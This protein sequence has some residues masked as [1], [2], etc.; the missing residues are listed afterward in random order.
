MKFTA[1]YGHNQRPA[2]LLAHYPLYRS[3]S[4]AALKQNVYARG[5]GMFCKVEVD[6]W[7]QC[8]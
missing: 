7:L 3:L 4:G 5:E 1:L 6:F 2:F 8:V